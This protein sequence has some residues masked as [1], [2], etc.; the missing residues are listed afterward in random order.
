MQDR[1]LGLS[2]LLK[3]IFS[4]FLWCHHKCRLLLARLHWLVQTKSVG[5]RSCKMRRKI[6]KSKS[7]K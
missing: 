7:C 1:G 5:W 6:C 2:C 4:M 3:A